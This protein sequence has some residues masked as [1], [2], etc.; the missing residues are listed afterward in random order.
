MHSLTTSNYANPEQLRGTACVDSKKEATLVEPFKSKFSSPVA[1]SSDTVK[2]KLSEPSQAGD[3]I[4]GEVANKGF[5]ELPHMV[6]EDTN[7]KEM[8]SCNSSNLAPT[9]NVK[10]GKKNVSSRLGHGL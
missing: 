9:P 5:G 1:I 2:A 8:E 6:L 4:F 7:A 3:D 10:G